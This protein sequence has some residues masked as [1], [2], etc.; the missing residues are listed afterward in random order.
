MLQPHQ[1][2]E[3][4]EDGLLGRI[5]VI[6]AQPLSQRAASYDQVAEELLTELQ[7]SDQEGSA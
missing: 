5:E 7:R 3:H 2:A 4:G 6:E 1:A